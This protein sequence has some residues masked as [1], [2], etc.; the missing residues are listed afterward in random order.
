MLMEFVFIDKKLLITFGENTFNLWMVD[1]EIIHHSQ[2]NP[3]G[4]II[5]LNK[6]IFYLHNKV[7]IMIRV[8]EFFYL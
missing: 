3:F 8:S 7:Y 1:K 4:E 5:F 2:F 6:F